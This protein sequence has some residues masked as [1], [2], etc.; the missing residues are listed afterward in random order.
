MGITLSSFCEIGY[1]RHRHTRA[2]QRAIRFTNAMHPIGIEVSMNRNRGLANRLMGASW[3]GIR[4]ARRTT[5]SEGNWRPRK[6]PALP[7]ALIRAPTALSH[8]RKETRYKEN[9]NINICNI[10]NA[11]S[12]RLRN[13]TLLT[14]NPPSIS[15][16]SK[17]TRVVPRNP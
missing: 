4:G 12:R 2:W 5:L 15:H 6:N 9:R 10:R 11:R 14:P 1:L 3:R 17:R 13:R 8:V 16:Q 7:T